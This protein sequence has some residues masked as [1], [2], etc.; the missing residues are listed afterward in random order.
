MG[1]PTNI[2]YLPYCYANKTNKGHT[3]TGR[4]GLGVFD[5]DWNLVETLCNNDDEAKPLYA[6]THLKRTLVSSFTYDASTFQEGKQYYIALYAQHAESSRPTIVRTPQGKKDWYRATVTDG[7]VVLEAKETI[8]A[9]EPQTGFKGDVNGDGKVD[10]ADIAAV[11]S[12]MKA[13]NQ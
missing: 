8:T 12:I 6:G 4:L 1:T 5:K 13:N 11:I 2:T 3:F 7:K 10:V 9:E